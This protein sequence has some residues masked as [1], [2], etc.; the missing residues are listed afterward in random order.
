M[1]NRVTYA[2]GNPH[3]MVIDNTLYESD[4]PFWVYYNNKL[5]AKFWNKEAAKVHIKFLI[6][7]Q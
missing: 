1:G 3:I 5:N 6:R 4:S 2:I 7:N